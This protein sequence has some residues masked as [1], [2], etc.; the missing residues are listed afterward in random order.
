MGRTISYR[1]RAIRREPL[2]P[3]TATRHAIEW[4]IPDV[5]SLHTFVLEHLPNEA[6]GFPYQADRREQENWLLRHV[7][8][9]LLLAKLE[10]WRK[11]EERQARCMNHDDPFTR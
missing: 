3:K 5:A 10:A 9:D 11:H 2:P 4:Q 1:Q 8:T 7:S 6:H